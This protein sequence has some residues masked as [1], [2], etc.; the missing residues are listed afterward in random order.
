MNVDRRAQEALFRHSVLGPLLSRTLKR[1]E[2]KRLL[3]ELASQYWMCADGKTRQ[4]AAKTLEEWY[5][6]HS[7]DQR[8]RTLNYGHHHSD[9]T[10][11]YGSP[12]L[13]GGEHGQSRPCKKHLTSR[14]GLRLSQG[15]PAAQAF[16]R[17]R[18]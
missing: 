15:R 17:R 13:A 7:G 12:G 16:L 14:C 4:V 6:S 11:H 5:Y 2:L 1:G 3:K 9:I 10:G 18:I 8:W